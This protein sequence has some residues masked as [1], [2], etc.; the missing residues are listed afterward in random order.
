VKIG[1]LL[2][3]AL[4][5]AALAVWFNPL[6]VPEATDRPN[7]VIIVSDDQRADT[8]T[9]QFMP[10]VTG[11]FGDPT[12]ATAFSNSFVSNSL[13]CPSRASILTGTYSHTTGVYGNEPPNG[14]F[15]SFDDSVSI[16]TALD[17]D[18]QTIFVGKYLNGNKGY[19]E[20]VP[21]GWNRWFSVPTGAYYNYVAAKNGHPTDL[22]GDSPR[23]YSARVL[24]K[25]AIGDV[26][27]AVS[28]NEPFLL[29]YAPA[30]PHGASP[31]SRMDPGVHTATPGPRDVDRFAGIAPY[32][33]ASYGNRDDV[34]DMP[35]YIQNRTWD[36]DARRDS[37]IIRQRQLEATYSMDREIG[38]LV[39]TLPDD[40]LII[41]MS[42]NGLL[43]GEH[44]WAT[45]KV[46][47]EESIR[48]P[49]FIRW[50]V[51]TDLSGVD[52][53]RLAL[54]I[55]LVPTILDVAGYPP[56]TP[57]ASAHYVGGDAPVPPEGESL[58]SDPPRTS[59]LLEHW[60]AEGGVPGYCGL[61]TNE[62]LMYVRYWEGD[63]RDNGFEE[64]YDVV[65][66]PL[67]QHN[68]AFDPAFD[69]E[70]A[71]LRTET[72]VACRPRPPRYSWNR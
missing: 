68:L 16:A 62:G 18:Y 70:Q 1:G 17:P 55:D 45:K 41:F 57:T 7:I 9:P 71:S 26:S 67:E 59:F 52:E 5:V 63:S 2:V 42:D 19:D 65:A 13:C 66:D 56:D 28:A 21:P 58:Y 47:Y 61:R 36:A 44:R 11:L 25:E 50:P 14:G 46:P 72:R 20:Y 51:G 10:N 12:R 53:S 43:W 15:V 6:S 54:N 37:D 49:L 32:R 33:P 29:L 38:R 24:T 48:V 34:S 69:Q 30:A 64:L 60:N 8:V 27:S 4:V 22:Y 40:T 3:A 23:D 39:A 35:R 31:R